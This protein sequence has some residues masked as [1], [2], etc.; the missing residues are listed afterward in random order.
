MTRV[1]F[2]AGLMIVFISLVSFG[3]PR[4]YLKPEHSN[5][6]NSEDSFLY[7]PG[8]SGNAD[9]YLLSSIGWS[10]HPDDIWWTGFSIPPG[11]NNSVLAMTIYNG[12]LVVAGGFTAAGNEEVNYIVA[13][14]G[15]SWIALGPGL[16]G[17]VRTLLTYNDYLIA[18]GYFT[19]AGGD[20][21]KYIAAWNGTSW[22]EFGSGMNGV[23]QALTIYDGK[24]IAAGEF[25]RAGGAVANYIAAWDGSSWSELGSGLSDCVRALGVYEGR[26]IAGGKNSYGPGVLKQVESLHGTE[27][28]G[29]RWGRE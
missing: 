15:T 9:G 12:D 14:N 5:Q 19:I 26:L 6:Q 20:S 24:L 3:K 16:N 1:A 8:E 11:V 2:F 18:G 22:S 10:S 7:M 13:W 28:P 4:Q 23:V 25:T 29:S 27:Y 21:A 17:T